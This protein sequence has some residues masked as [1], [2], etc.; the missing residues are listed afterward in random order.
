MYRRNLLAVCKV[1]A[2]SSRAATAKLLSPKQAKGGKKFLR[3]NLI[4]EKY[5]RREKEIKEVEK[6]FT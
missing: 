3:K 1:S 6:C 5:A 2:T 4:P